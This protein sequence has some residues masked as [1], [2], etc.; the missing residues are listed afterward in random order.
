M[1]FQFMQTVIQDTLVRI[2]EGNVPILFTVMNVKVN[3]IVIKPAVMYL[4][5]V[6]MPQKVLYHTYNM[7]EKKPFSVALK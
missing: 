5:D 6:Q 1:Y 7:F 3:V 2:V 4:S